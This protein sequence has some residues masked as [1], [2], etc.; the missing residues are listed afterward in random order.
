[1]KEI[2][3]EA[4]EAIHNLGARFANGDG[5]KKN[6]ATAIKWMLI[7]ARM[8][9]VL[10]QEWL[11]KSYEFGTG[12]K[13]DYKEAIKWYRLAAAQGSTLAQNNLGFLYWSGRGVTKNYRKAVKW[14]RQAAMHD[15]L[16]DE[17]KESNVDY[18][19]YNLGCCYAK[20]QGVKQDWTQAA[21]WYQK[22]A[23]KGHPYAQFNLADCFENGHGVTK[24]IT[25]AIDWY[26]RAVGNGHKKALSKLLHLILKNNNFKNVNE[27]EYHAKKHDAFKEKVASFLKQHREIKKISSLTFKQTTCQ[28]R[29][30]IDNNSIADYWVYPNFSELVASINKNGNYFILS[31]SCGIPECIDLNTPFKITRKDKLIEWVITDPGPARTVTFNFIEYILAIYD[32]LCQVCT[33]FQNHPIKHES[34]QTFDETYENNLPFLYSRE[35][36][37]AM[38]EYVKKSFMDY[39]RRYM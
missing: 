24:D 6:H 32:G 17:N 39:I 16:F 11:G 37:E 5:V 33:S 19:Q 36:F 25:K 4:A 29:M 18:A 30:L 27:S 21:N 31:C 28:V 35:T 26:M 15:N 7:S 10:S 23:D 3:K 34:T 8:G 2:Y 14:Y 13:I 1:M 20:G 9:D 22:S 12:V 38:R